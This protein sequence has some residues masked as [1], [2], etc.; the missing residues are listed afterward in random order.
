MAGARFFPEIE[1]W[2]GAF[3]RAEK[4]GRCRKKREFFFRV[5][6]IFAVENS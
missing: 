4:E 3:I 1:R 2:D 5:F 6:V